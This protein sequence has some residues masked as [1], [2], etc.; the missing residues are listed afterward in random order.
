MES[1]DDDRIIQL[2][3]SNKKLN[4]KF[5]ELNEKYSEIV[6]QLKIVFKLLELRD[7]ELKLIRNF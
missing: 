5:I 4:D 3:Q 2:K 7:Q 1:D 6:E